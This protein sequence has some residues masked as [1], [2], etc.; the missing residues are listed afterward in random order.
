MASNAIILKGWKQYEAK[1]KVAP[2]KVAASMNAQVAVSA[3]Y[4]AN[5][6]RNRSPH[7]EGRL[8]AS[9]IAAQEKPGDWR[10]TV[11]V[12]YAAYMEFGTKSRVEIPAGLASYAAQFK[13]PGAKGDARAMIYRWCEQHGIPRE[14]WGAV[15]IKIMIYGV[16]AH[17]FLFPSVEEERPKFYD[18]VKKALN[19]IT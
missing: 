2:V 9:I 13:G 4:I 5:G 8:R 14:A 18:R 10:V 7:N 17:P 12:D 1:L 3:N 16:K 6:A 11:G 15:Y 19:E